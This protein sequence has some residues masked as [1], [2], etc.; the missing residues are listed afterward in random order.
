MKPVTDGMGRAKGLIKCTTGLGVHLIKTGI[1]VAEAEQSDMALTHSA[2]GPA[3][4]IMQAR[5][6]G[7]H[8]HNPC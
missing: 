6:G 2:S 7:R 1:C 3:A 4:T 8:G 5:P